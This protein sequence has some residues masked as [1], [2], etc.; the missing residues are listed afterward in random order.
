MCQIGNL[1]QYI[2][3]SYCQH[4]ECLKIGLHELLELTATIILSLFLSLSLLI[5]FADG[6]RMKE[7]TGAGVY[8]QSVGRRLSISVGRYATVF[9]A[10]KCA[11]LACVYEIQLQNRLEKYTIIC[12][13]SQAALKAL[14]A[15]RT[16]SPLVQ[17]CQ[18]ALNDI[19]TQY[20]VG[21]YWVCGHA[22]IRGNEMS[23]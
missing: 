11:M 3:R 12:S 1:G 9:Q 7:G 20:A 17:Q 16:V 21:L 10:E 18:K 5:W 8:G 19:S 6:S 4:F 13:D 2:L 14:Q 23:R 22:G 15:I